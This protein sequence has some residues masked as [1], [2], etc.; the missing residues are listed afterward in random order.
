M[1]IQNLKLQ[2]LKNMNIHIKTTILFLGSTKIKTNSTHVVKCLG[3]EV[4][5]DLAPKR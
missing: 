3:E 5:L 1:H 2:K 4:G